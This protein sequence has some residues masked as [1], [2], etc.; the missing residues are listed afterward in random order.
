MKKNRVL[1]SYAM[2]TYLNQEKG[3]DH[4]KKVL[5]EAQKSG[6]S[7]FMNQMDVGETYYVLHRKRGRDKADYFL[8]TIMAGLPITPVPNDYEFVIEAARIKAEHP[9]SFADCFSI[10]TARHANAVI[11]TGNPGFKKV[12]Q[13]VDIEWLQ[14]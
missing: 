2:L 5:S 12:E 13:L 8:G 3:F 14:G 4:V 6:R 9:V 1:D 10:C 7:I 11:L